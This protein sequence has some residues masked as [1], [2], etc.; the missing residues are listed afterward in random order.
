MAL[1][2]IQKVKLEVGLNAFEDTYLTDDELQYFLD[3]HN[4]SIRKASLD[5]AKTLL[6][7][8]AQFTHSKTD[9]ELEYWGGEFFVNYMS[10]LKM[11]IADPNYSIA[12]QGAMPYAGGIKID[13]IQA[14]I[15][16]P[17]NN[18]SKITSNV[19]SGLYGVQDPFDLDYRYHTKGFFDV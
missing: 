14:N 11:Y 4:N 9:A 19:P 15:A 17:N 12:T 3:K 16:N 5:A 2:D 13:D 8:L 6:F 10:A 18:T 1:T 7:I